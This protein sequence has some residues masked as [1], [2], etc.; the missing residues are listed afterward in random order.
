MSAFTLT[1]SASITCFI[2]DTEGWVS[3][4]FRGQRATQAVVVVDNIYVVYLVHIL[5]PKAHL[6][7]ALGHRPVFVDNNH[8]G[9]HK[10]TGCVF[11]VFEK[12]DNIAGLL[13]VVDMRNN[14]VALFFVELL[15]K[16]YSIVSIKVIDLLGNLLGRHVLDEFQSL[17][18]IEFHKHIGG[19]IFV[20]KFE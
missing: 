20:E 10:T 12:V 1:G 8:L 6:L 18:L 7:D 17:V 4:I 11:V 9:A 5:G 15:N 16:V 19:C 3:I 14:L 13:N 2:F